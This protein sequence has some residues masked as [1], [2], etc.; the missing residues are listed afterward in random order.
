MFDGTI[1]HWRP[2]TAKAQRTYESDGW[3]GT[4]FA[5]PIGA[6]VAALY[7][8]ANPTASPSTVES[9]IKSNAT[10]SSMPAPG[11]IL[12][13]GCSFIPAP[14]VNPIDDS[15]IYVRQ[16]YLDFLSRMPDPS[17]QAFW[18]NE[19]ESCGADQTCRHIKRINVSK[20]F[21]ESIEFQETGGFV[22]RINRMSFPNFN[23]DNGERIGAPQPRMERFFL[24]Q[25][26][27][28]RTTSSA[29]AHPRSSKR[30]S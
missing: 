21:F 1:A 15:T 26:K 12:Y 2:R 22:Y 23:D 17:G 16:Q 27:S 19:I 8:E 11:P 14:T 18:V 24:D 13:S 10:F 25:R 3:A 6:G 29:S 28:A 7:L 9:A 20:A 4:S 5:S 30:R